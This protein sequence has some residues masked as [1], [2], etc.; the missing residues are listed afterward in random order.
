M[1]AI[2]NPGSINGTVYA[3]ASKSMTQRAYAAALLHKGKSI[4]HGTGRSNDEQ[5]ALHV[6]EQLGA[7]VRE[8]G[9]TKEITSEGIKPK[10]HEINCQES[11][12][13][14]R[15]FTPIAALSDQPITI[16][17]AGSLL[18]RPMNIFGEL[19][20]QLN[21]SLHNFH[22]H[23]PFTVQGPLRSKVLR[24]DG[25]ISSQF[26]SGLLFALSYNITAPVTI[27]VSS[28]K[29]KPYIDL[30][31]DMLNQFGKPITNNNYESFYINP[32]LFK[33]NPTIEINVEGDWSNAAYWLVA[34]AING[35]IT[36]KGLDI[37]SNQADRA[38]LPILQ[39]C[40][41]D[42]KTLED[43]LH[44][45]TATLTAFETDA[46]DYPDLFPALAI[47]AGC[48]K[49]ESYIKGVHRLYHKESNRV[50]SISEMLSQLGVPLSIEDDTLCITGVQVFDGALIDAYN[51]HRIVMAA[52]VAAVKAKRAIV[53]DGAE[54][55]NK[56]Y[57]LFFDAL[58]NL[59]ID[60]TLNND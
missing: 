57:P 5:A 1:Q 15:L 39:Q 11:G 31:L 8:H 30:T 58:K 40:G 38:V 55:V 4:V 47:L 33:H 27:Y 52:A 43:A 21:V 6:I 23:L 13:C 41:A 25:S 53:I 42:I 18:N 12:L 56:S 19:L 14:A 45:K 37:N 35:D 44:I 29:S 17:G 51:D 48:C 50:A 54:A 16:K 34:G 26:L 9:Q 10:S 60:C 20:P 28:L 46:T 2:I 22:D 59:G 32:A 24:V 3:P 7:T 36:L 49:G